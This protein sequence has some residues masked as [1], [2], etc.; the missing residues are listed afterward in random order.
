MI[1]VTGSLIFKI[2]IPRSDPGIRMNTKTVA[3][4]PETSDNFPLSIN[5]GK[6][7]KTEEMNHRNVRIIRLLLF[8]SVLSTS[9]L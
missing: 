9:Q 6:N 7:S 4:V 1:A 5:P 8:F 3:V 2:E